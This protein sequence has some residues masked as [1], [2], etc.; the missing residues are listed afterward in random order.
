[1]DRSASPEADIPPVEYHLVTYSPG[2]NWV[3]GKG[4]FE[5]PLEGHAEFQAGLA[6]R[7][8]LV[9]SGPLLDRDGGISIIRAADPAIARALI[10]DDPALVNGVFAA[11]VAPFLVAFSALPGFGRP[12]GPGGSGEP[13]PVVE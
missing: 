6:E 10:A 13:A 11:D 2:K 9:M 1:M 3:D 12:A 8:I 5:Q 4:L 7:D